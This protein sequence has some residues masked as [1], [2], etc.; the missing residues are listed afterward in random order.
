M[1]YLLIVNGDRNL[2]RE[3]EDRLVPGHGEGDFLIINSLELHEMILRDKESALEFR[4]EYN[5]DFQD[6][7]ITILV[8]SFIMKGFLMGWFQAGTISF[9]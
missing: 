1:S 8:H 3:L 2:V 7:N 5:I 9:H 4:H 6:W